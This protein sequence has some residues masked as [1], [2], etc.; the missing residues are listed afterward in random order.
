MVDSTDWWRDAVVYQV[1]P[2]SFADADGDGVGDLAG[3]AE[4]FGHVVGLGVDAVWLTPFQTS[5]QADHGYDVSDYVDVDPLFGTLG[6]V[7]RLLAVAHDHGLR[8]LVDLVPN[9]CSSEHPLFRAALAAGPGSPERERFH[10]RPGRGEDGGEPPNNWTS[11]FGGPAW[12]R[13]VG[14][15][16][17]P[18]EWYLHMYAPE[19]P[20]WNWD[21]PATAELFDGVLR[22]W[23]DRGFDGVRIDVAHGLF[24]AADLPDL[25]DPSVQRPLL[26]RSNP[27]A[28]DREEVHDVYRRWRRIADTYDPP[29]CL[30]GEINLPA[31]RAARY[32]RPDELHLG[33]AFA[34]IHTPWDPAAL[35]S[36]IDDL[37]AASTV[38]GG[39]VTWVTENHDVVRSATRY[40]G[41]SRGH[42]RARAALLLM[43]ALPGTVY[44]YQGQ[45]LG[46]PEVD[47]P[48][49]ARQDPAWFRSGRTRDGCRVPLPWTRDGASYGF[50]PAGATAAPWLPQPAGWGDTS[51]EA[52]DS[53]EASTLAF[54]RSALRLRR[55]LLASSVLGREVIEQNE[56]IGWLD[57]P[58]GV[59]AFTRGGL[60][61]VVNAGDSPVPLPDGEVLATSGALDTGGHLPRDTAAWVLPSTT[62]GSA[63]R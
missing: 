62:N 60:V 21:H 31:D 1:Y 17:M 24:K 39:P 61:C 30:V 46:L 7:D 8:M 38:N 13:V 43:L 18:G 5:P 16:G 52:Q 33:F 2:R 37:L 3:I 49:G 57:A 59:L 25:P 44:L 53:D 32:V 50:S 42:A 12:T 9:H 47:V 36:T 6:D 22:F 11:V 23:F 14:P 51:V 41:G 26:L 15:D 27:L 28:C 55:G 48:P 56:T 4:R 19:Q 40:G 63:G 29:R 58:P 54:T 10:F 34:F 20:D 45:E 35:R